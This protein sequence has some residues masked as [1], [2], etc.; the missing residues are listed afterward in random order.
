MELPRYRRPD[1]VLV[2]LYRRSH[3]AYGATSVSDAVGMVDR[4]LYLLLQ[5][6]P[7]RS[8]SGPIWQTVVGTVRWTEERIQAA[9]REV[10]EETGLTMLRGITAIGYAFSFP[11]R[12]AKDQESWYAPGQTTIDNTVFAA[13][14]FGR[15][16]IL[17]SPEHQSYGWFSFEEALERLHWPEEKEALLRLHPLV[18]G[19]QAASI[20]AKGTR[21][22]LFRE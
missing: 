16:P 12:L 10:F 14:V 18:V 2:F 17:L 11:I 1:K 7:S 6:H 15:R 13:E 21:Q 3:A 20:E 4:S 22:L 19:Q 8:E 9:R 5:R